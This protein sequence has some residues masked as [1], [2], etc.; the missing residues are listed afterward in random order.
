MKTTSPKNFILQLGALIALYLSVTSLIILIFSVTNLKFPDE[1][2][3]YWESESA[4]ASVRN[5][6]AMLIV[7]FPAF[8]TFTRLSNQ[9]RRKYSQ[10]EYATF[11]K[12][13]VYLTI[14]GGVLILLGDLV[15]LIIYFL[16]GEITTR[17]LVK[18]VAL[19]LVVGGAL[20]Y[21]V[22]DVKG[23][24]K[25]QV[26]KALYFAVGAVVVVVG[27]LLYGYSYIETPSEAREMRLDEQQVSDLRDMYWHVDEYYR[28]NQQ[29]PET[30]EDAY[31][32]DNV[33]TAPEGRADYTYKT[34]G[35]ESFEFCVT[36]MHETQN[37][38][39]GMTKSVPIRD[40]GATLPHQQQNYNWDHKAGETCFERTVQ[41]DVLDPL[42][43]KMIQ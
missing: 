21:Y 16:N 12:W 38:M 40:V 2:A 11:A 24:F 6:I 7:F 4:R 10:G 25:N 26:T 43:P 42:L 14:L 28:Q 9:D 22:L 18:V 5:S 31:T 33:P 3:N 41:T 23:Y 37:I 13:L 19:L 20:G 30:I 35:D 34:A 17:F 1:I 32:R 39:D 36:F 15:T 8:I 27:S 29:L